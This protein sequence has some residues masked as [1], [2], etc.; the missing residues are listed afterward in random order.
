M[1]KPVLPIVQDTIAHILWKAD[2]LATVH[3]HHGEYHTHQEM[4]T[5]AQEEENNPYPSAS[6]PAE[7]VSVH[8]TLISFFSLPPLDVQKQMLGRG[9][10]T[11]ST[12]YLNKLYPPPKAC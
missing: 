1:C 3:E 8:I 4:A 5:A 10:Y 12:L 6:K 11:L 9:I 2:H 7:P